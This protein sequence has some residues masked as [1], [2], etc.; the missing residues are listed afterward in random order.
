[1]KHIFYCIT[2]LLFIAGLNNDLTA[3]PQYYNYTGAG[4][5]SNSFPFNVAAGKDI[6][7][8]YLAGEFNQPSAAPAGNITSISLFF[9]GGFGPAT[10]TDLTI[11]LGQTTLTSLTAGAFYTG[12]LTTVYYHASATLSTP[13]S[14]WLTITLD[15]PF[16]YDPTQSLVVDIGQCGATGTLGGLN[17]YTNLSGVRRVWS[18]GGCPFAPYNSSSIYVYNMGF[19]MAAAPPP[20]GVTNPAT[21]V[22]SSIATLNGTMNANGASTTVT[23]E[24][25]LTNAYGSTVVG[26][27]SPVTGSTPTTII[28]GIVGLTPNTLYH[29]RIKGVNANGTGTGADLTFTT[30][31]PPPSLVTT[32]ASN[33]LASTATVNGTVNANGASTAVTFEYGLTTAYG[34]TVSASPS[35]VTG[36]TVT[37]VSAP[38]TGLSQNTLYHYR[39]GGTNSGGT[40]NGLDMTFTTGGV[41]VVVTNLP[42]NV[43]N[44]T[45]TLNGTVTANNLS[46]T[47]TFEWGMTTAYGTTAPGVPSPVSGTTATAVSANISGL[48]LGTI[49]HYRCVGVNGA[50]TTNGADQ[51]FTAGC[52]AP[53]APGTITGSTTVCASSANN[54]YSIT[55][56]PTATSYNWTVPAGATVT[57]GQGT[58]S[59]TVTFGASPGNVS[60]QAVGSC[61]SSVFTNL[62]VTVNPLPVPTVTGPATACQGSSS[63]TYTTQTGMSAYTW[64]VSSGG[65]ILS[66]AG[67][68]SV[69]VR[70]NNTGAQAV[71]VSYTNASGCAAA[72]PSAY[73][74]TVNPAP[75]PTITGTNS[76]CATSGYYTYTTE[77]GFTGYVWTVSSGGSIF[78][79]Q[80]TSALMV[81][82]GTAGAQSVSVNYTNSGGCSAAVPV[83]FPVTVNSVPGPVGAV[84]GPVS[85][86]AGAQGVNYSCAPVAGA[87]AYAW[88]LPSGFH[89]VSGDNTNSITVNIDLAAVSGSITVA[90]NTICGNGASSPPFALTV[91]AIPA[92]AG[93][94]SGPASVCAGSVGNIYSVASIANATGYTWT[95]PAGATITAG[96]NTN[97]ITV[98]FGNTTGSGNITV[99][100][101]NSCGTGI[102]SPLL[103][104]TVNAVPAR[105]A[106]T[107]VGNVLTSSASSGNQ[108]FYQGSAISGATSQTYTAP[109]ANPGW[110]W[111]IVTLNGCASDSSNNVYIAGVGIG[112]LQ[113]GNFRVYPVPNDGQFTVSMSSA[114]KISV[115][116]RVYNELGVQV[117][118]MTDISVSGNVEKHIDIRPASPGVYTIVF[119]NQDTKV[120]R[121][122]LVSK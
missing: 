104:V 87:T 88:T 80:G 113:T 89:V 3:Q 22:T 27:P 33:V 56:V 19:N 106:V 76:L 63:N 16:P 115:N 71:N 118:Q 93:A 108:W 74:V 107:V 70:W 40:S 62:A 60:V 52:Q 116:L 101:T 119:S 41:P 31:F 30:G 34:S 54:T 65:T 38:L 8:I 9:N 28:A 36:S 10:Y 7:L 2:I 12:A 79:G 43:T 47:V 83:Q 120:I 67:T 90:G 99:L 111:T 73:A 51:Q 85:V 44:T 105:P 18:V 37:A 55:A 11:K 14:S 103:A 110:Y 29:F 46:T 13:A 66:G 82:W 58:L 95:L 122:I 24:Y 4:N 77:P 96:A 45:A 68:S 26:I 102:V 114:E 117:F 64:T 97:S 57:A 6:Q 35:P 17:A 72:I 50:G 81:Y 98:S 75:A 78:A 94:I 92:A 48:T 32:A 21:S 23:F 5:G 53:V 15:S 61:G 59:A 69:T 1:M 39:V 49:Y 86:C 91:N 112:E 25:G 20:V 42:S 100:G 84:S 109:A 121:K